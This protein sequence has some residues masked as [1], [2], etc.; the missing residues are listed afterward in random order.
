MGRG[1]SYNLKSCISTG[2]VLVLLK[3]YRSHAIILVFCFNIFSLNFSNFYFFFFLS[4][5][6]EKKKMKLL[7]GP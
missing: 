1:V 3:I 5:F 7:K 2:F 6:L 4:F